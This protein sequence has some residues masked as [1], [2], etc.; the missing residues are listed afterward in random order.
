M[1]DGRPAFRNS[2]LLVVLGVGPDNANTQVHRASSNTV[3]R[4]GGEEGSYVRAPEVR[5]VGEA[6]A[7]WPKPGHGGRHANVPVL[8][9]L[10]SG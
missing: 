3:E 8:L 7:M 6:G 4:K 10:T 1:C 9:F 5:V 2:R